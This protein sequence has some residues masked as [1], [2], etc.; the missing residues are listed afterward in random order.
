MVFFAPA[1]TLALT[2]APLLSNGPGR[3]DTDSMIAGASG[4]RGVGV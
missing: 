4:N 1:M 3:R 2:A